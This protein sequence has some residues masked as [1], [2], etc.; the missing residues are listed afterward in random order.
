MLE[1]EAQ[2]LAEKTEKMEMFKRLIL[3]N[4]VIEKT[5]LKVLAK[6]KDKHDIGKHLLNLNNIFRQ[7]KII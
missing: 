6:P 5:P 2:K 4:K 1:E 3:K 7:D